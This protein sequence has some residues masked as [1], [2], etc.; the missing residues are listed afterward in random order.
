MGAG[1]TR[2][3]SLVHPVAVHEQCVAMEVGVVDVHLIALRR[4][5]LPH[6]ATLPRLTFHIAEAASA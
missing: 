5:M 4:H 1:V 3:Y 2:A 6:P